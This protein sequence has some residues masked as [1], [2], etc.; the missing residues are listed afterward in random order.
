MNAFAHGRSWPGRT[1]KSAAA[2][3]AAAMLAVAAAGCSAGSGTGTQATGSQ[4]AT[5]SPAATV[6]A[7]PSPTATILT[8]TKLNS[9]LLPISAMPAGFKVLTQYTRNSMTDIV[10][11]SAAPMPLSQWCQRLTASSWIATAGM[12]SASFAQSDYMN[13]ASQNEIMQE[14]DAFQGNDAQTVMGNL[15]RVFK[16]C[17]TFTY[18]SS[19]MTVNTTTTRALVPGA[20]DEG[21][22]AVLTAPVFSGGETAAAV[23]VGN[24]VVT[25]L[26]SSSQTDLG[27]A[28]VTIAETLAAKVKAAGG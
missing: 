14:I 6:R 16:Q 2:A 4:P 12:N 7:T 18:Q 24:T 19:G 22:K 11:D 25:V 8:G 27:A 15:W 9:L 1:L 20:G 23:R 13:S 21:I 10:P 17:R 5:S 3:G 28:A 26:D